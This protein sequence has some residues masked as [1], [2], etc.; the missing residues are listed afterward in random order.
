MLEVWVQSVSTL[1]EQIYRDLD[2]GLRDRKALTKA[3]VHRDHKGA[4][5]HS[6]SHPIPSTWAVS[7]TPMKIPHAS[8]IF[9]VIWECFKM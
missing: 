9:F 4:E 6:S 7:V 3:Y 2:I 1:K 8:S 5:T